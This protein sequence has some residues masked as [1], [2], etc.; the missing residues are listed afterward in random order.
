MSLRIY[1]E[2]EEIPSNMR[3]VDYNDIF[4]NGVSLKDDEISEKIMSEIDQAHYSSEKTFIGRDSSLGNLNKENLSTGCKTLLNILYSPCE[5]FDVV[6][7]GE[8]ALRLLPLIKDGNILWKTPVLHGNTTCDI[9]I[10]GKHFTDFREFLKY[11]M[12]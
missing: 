5:C 7:C 10:H 2:K 6:E 11:V 8:N 9:D 1:T 12:D 4:F 3:F